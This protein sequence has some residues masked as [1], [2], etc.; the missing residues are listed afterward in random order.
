MFIAPSNILTVFL[1]VLSPFVVSWETQTGFQRPNCHASDCFMSGKNKETVN[2]NH[3][4][5]WE[6]EVPTNHIFSQC[7]VYWVSKF[8]LNLSVLLKCL[9]PQPSLLHFTSTVC[10]PDILISPDEK[11]TKAN[12]G[13]GKYIWAALI[14]VSP[15]I[16]QS[17]GHV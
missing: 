1:E 6:N 8:I 10:F 3:H 12:Q 4:S 5:D 13:T 9:Q 2:R 17:T 14:L 15:V 11:P 7:D 16:L